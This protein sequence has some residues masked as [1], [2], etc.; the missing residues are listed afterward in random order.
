MVDTD[1]SNVNPFGDM[2]VTTVIVIEVASM[3]ISCVAYNCTNRQK[4][5]SGV[6]FHR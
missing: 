4:I 1:G 6:S 5:G 3:V 2:L